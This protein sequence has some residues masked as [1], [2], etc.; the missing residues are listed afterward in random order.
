MDIIT[1]N[2]DELY[3]QCL[4]I[5]FKVFVD[6]QKVPKNEEV[7]QFEKEC[8]HFLVKIDDE[9][10]GTARFRAKSEN[11]VKVERVAVHSAYRGR[12][13][14]FKLMEH[15]HE[16]AK[17]NGYTYA[18]LGAQVHAVKFYESLGYEI[19]SDIFLDAGIEHYMMK[20]SL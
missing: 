11:T 17:I 12:G 18:V 16:V 7:D 20:K 2:T 14:G 5:R 15:M 13:I 1:A 3:E 19:D 8:T 10:V 6:E 9:Y 4:D